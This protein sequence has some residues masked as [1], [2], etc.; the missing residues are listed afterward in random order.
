M[1]KNLQNHKYGETV[2]ATKEDLLNLPEIVQTLFEQYQKG[3]LELS[4]PEQTKKELELW[5]ISN[6]ELH[7]WEPPNHNTSIGLEICRGCKRQRS[8]SDLSNI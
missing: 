2:S 6:H 4:S 3:E 1:D 8:N 7:K 5:F